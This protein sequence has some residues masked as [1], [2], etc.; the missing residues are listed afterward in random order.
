MSQADNECLTECYGPQR[1][2]DAPPSSSPFFSILPAVPSSYQMTSGVDVDV[3]FIWQ[4]TA[5][6][7]VI[8]DEHLDGKI[9]IEELG[10]W[11]IQAGGTNAEV[12][13][14]LEH[15]KSAGEAREIH[16]PEEDTLS[17]ERTRLAF[18]QAARAGAEQNARDTG[19]SDLRVDSGDVEAFLSSII[20]PS[21]STLLS[22]A[23]LALGLQLHTL[24]CPSNDEHLGKTWKLCQAFVKEPNID[25][26]IDGVQQQP[27]RDPIPHSIW[28]DI[29]QDK[30][31]V[32]TKLFTTM[33]LSYDRP[34]P[35]SRAIT[36]LVWKNPPPK[37]LLLAGP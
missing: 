13:T 22:P 2:L 5:V 10:T 33:E 8:L 21:T 34:P 26:L 20:H 24:S 7:S 15:A 11:L 1:K 12:K 29:I 23:L 27:L 30:F 6:L 35:L 16:P 3:K 17:V 28:K 36:C 31:I 37:K 14:Y 4:H 25:L 18:E 19:G 32:F 9:S